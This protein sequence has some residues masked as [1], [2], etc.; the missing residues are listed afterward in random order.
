MRALGGGAVL[1]IGRR[2]EVGPLLRRGWVTAE[3]RPE[4]GGGKRDPFPYGFVRLT[5]DGLRALA[6]AVE[7]FGWPEIVPPKEAA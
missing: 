2:R 7:R 4:S 6:L 1:V 5:P 3:I